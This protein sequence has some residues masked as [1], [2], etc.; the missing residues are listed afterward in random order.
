VLHL[1]G[2]GRRLLQQG[3]HEVRLYVTVTDKDGVGRTGA[4]HLRVR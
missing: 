1:S 2:P 3:S 4:A